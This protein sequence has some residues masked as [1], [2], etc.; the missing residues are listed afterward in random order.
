MKQN[1]WFKVH[2]GKWE[3]DEFDPEVTFLYVRA[4]DGTHASKKAGKEAEKGEVV[5]SIEFLGYQ[6]L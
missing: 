2:F 3:D 6:Q 1:Y 5:T 4:W